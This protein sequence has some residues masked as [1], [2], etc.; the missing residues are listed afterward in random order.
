[1]AGG[2]E[3]GLQAHTLTSHLCCVERSFS[4]L[5]LG[6]F[7]LEV[8]RCRLLKSVSDIDYFFGY[9]QSRFGFSVSV[10]EITDLC[11]YFSVIAKLSVIVDLLRLVQRLLSIVGHACDKYPDALVKNEPN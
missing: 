8:G 5:S 1:L 3:L 7:T 4:G 6:T 9:F 2:R 10:G 11:G